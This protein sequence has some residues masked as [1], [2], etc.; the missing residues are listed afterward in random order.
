MIKGRVAIISR[1]SNS[2][3][4]DIRMLSD[5]LTRRGDIEVVVLCKMLEHNYFS[6]MLHLMKQFHAFMTC[7]VIVLD[8]YCIMASIMRNHRRTNVVQMWH[9]LSAVKKFSWQTVGLRDGRSPFI[10]KAMHMHE[11]YDYVLCASDI[12]AEHFCAAFRVTRDKI[13]KLGLP[14]I[15]RIREDK[16]KVADVI[17]ARYPELAGNRKNILYVPTFRKGRSVDVQSLANALDPER[18]NLIVKLHPIDYMSTVRID[19]QGIIFDEEFDSYDMLG[20]ADAVIS[21]YSSYVV[22]ASLRDIPLYLYTYDY[23]DY[24][25]RVGL[26]VRYEEEA[27]GRYAYSSAVQLTKALEEPYDFEA[28][29]KFRDKYIDVDTNN[30]TEQLTDFIEKLI[31]KNRTGRY[32]SR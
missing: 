11:G 8:T 32:G 6:Y 13:V 4:L 14:R 1:E 16:T 9:A 15:D 26:N 27:I 25:D 18:Y 29:R 7:D 5:S 22:E 31:D 21:D 2:P 17:Y 3:T 28:L 30:C 12:T 20:I 19:R 24:K 23:E 10:A